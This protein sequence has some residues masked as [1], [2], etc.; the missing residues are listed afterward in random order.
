M[1]DGKFTRIFFYQRTFL[2]INFIFLIIICNKVDLGVMAMKGNFTLTRA[3]EL[4][5]HY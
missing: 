2:K 1:T 5:Q 4:I 3:P